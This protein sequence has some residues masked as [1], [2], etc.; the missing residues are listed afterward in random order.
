MERAINIYLTIDIDNDF[1]FS[2]L[3]TQ[4]LSFDGLYYGLPSFIDVLEKIAEECKKTLFVTVFC[5]ADEQV[6]SAFGSYSYVF[7]EADALLSNLKLK[8]VKYELQWH[9][10]VYRK[11]GEGVWVQELEGKRVIK[12]LNSAY[13]ELYKNGFEIQCL[14]VGECFFCLEILTFMQEKKIYIDSTALPGR[15]LGHTNWVN[16]PSSPYY[17]SENDF[18]KPGTS[19]LL[20]VP[21][22]MIDILAPYDEH[23]KKRYLNLIYNINHLDLIDAIKSITHITTIIHPYELVL[24]SRD[25]NHH[26]L[27]GGEVAVAKNLKTLLSIPNIASEFLSRSRAYYE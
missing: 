7:E 1:L 5:R 18:L 26:Q 21:F 9:P 4:E 19:S 23:S 10:H 2:P 6:N 14:R 8:N 3:D 24:Y 25:S 22:T 11:N 17:I 13:A 15:D 16:S 27:W 12:Q 20:E